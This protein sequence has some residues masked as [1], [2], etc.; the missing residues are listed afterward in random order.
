MSVARTAL[1]IYRR[2]IHRV[3]DELVDHL[4]DVVGHALGDIQVLG[5]QLD[6]AR[7]GGIATV[8]VGDAG[9]ERLG[10]P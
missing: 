1:G 8:D 7:F 3:G 10:A 9:A 5:A 2:V 4:A 6:D